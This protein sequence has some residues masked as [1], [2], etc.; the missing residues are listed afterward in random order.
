MTCTHCGQ[1][2]ERLHER[3]VDDPVIRPILERRSGS[4]RREP[5]WLAYTRANG[6]GKSL[7]RRAA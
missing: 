4:E 5:R 3:R 6:M 7:D 2:H 1:Q